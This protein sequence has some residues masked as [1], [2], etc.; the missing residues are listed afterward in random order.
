[1]SRTLSDA[2]MEV[3]FGTSEGIRFYES[4]EFWSYV[5]AATSDHYAQQ[6]RA[7]HSGME[8]SVIFRVLNEKLNNK[9]LKKFF[10]TRLLNFS[11]ESIIF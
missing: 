3:V 2:A 6:E 9:E 4:N 1:M 7:I 11:K 8:E 5:D 10:L